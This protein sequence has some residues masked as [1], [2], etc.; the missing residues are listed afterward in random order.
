MGAGLLS[1]T[2]VSRTLPM[3]HTTYF[4]DKEPVIVVS[5]SDCSASD[6]DKLMVLVEIVGMICPEWR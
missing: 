3:K 2:G 4:H 1:V 6:G 5:S